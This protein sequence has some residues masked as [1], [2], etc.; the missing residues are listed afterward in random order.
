MI[1]IHWTTF[2]DNILVTQGTAR[3]LTSVIFLIS[4]GYFQTN[5]YSLLITDLLGIYARDDRLNLFIR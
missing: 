1:D 3:N 5:Q 4:S 2:Y